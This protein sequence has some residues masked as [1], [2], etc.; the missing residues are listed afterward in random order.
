MARRALAHAGDA[1]LGRIG[2]AFQDT[3]RPVAHGRWVWRMLPCCHGPT[4]PPLSARSARQATAHASFSW[5]HG[6]DVPGPRLSC[7]AAFPA[8]TPSRSRPM[9][10]SGGGEPGSG[11]DVLWYHTPTVRRRD[12]GSH[13][14]GTPLGR[15]SRAPTLC[16]RDHLDRGVR[17]RPNEGRYEDTTGVC[18]Q[19]PGSPHP[20]RPL[21]WVEPPSKEKQGLGPAANGYGGTACWDEGDGVKQTCHPALRGSQ[22]GSLAAHPPPLPGTAEIFLFG[23]GDGCEV[24][25]PPAR[26]SANRSSRPSQDDRNNFPKLFGPGPS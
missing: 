21:G 13:L 14:C 1:V 19:T 8:A 24:S 7:C 17:Q 10:A 6:A 18:H 5:D 15:A 23:E 3:Q 11:G 16:P 9:P 2:G 22:G 26:R 4:A 12:M 20:L 25:K